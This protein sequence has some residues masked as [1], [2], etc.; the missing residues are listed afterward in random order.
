MGSSPSVASGSSSLEASEEAVVEG[1]GTVPAGTRILWS[2]L[3]AGRD[4]DAYPN[5]L[6]FLPERWLQADGN[7]PSPP[8]VD[9]GS[10]IHRC[11][12]EHLAMLEATVMLAQLL[13]HFDWNLVNGASSLENQRQN[14]LIYPA[15]G[16]PVRF[17]P[18]SH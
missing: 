1:I 16:M 17:R 4:P 13:R 2:M 14:L 10:G 18:R 3:A 6:N 5:P 15:D 7:R 12:G 11:I 8:M 9:F